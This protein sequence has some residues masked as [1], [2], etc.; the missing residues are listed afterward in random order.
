MTK[1]PEKQELK[2]SSIDHVTSVVKGAIGVVPFAGPL[3][4]E[5]AGTLIPNQRI[6]RL[7]KFSE[8]HSHRL[9]DVEENK[10][11]TY[12]TDEN[13]TDAIE[14]SLRLAARSTSE[15]GR[16]SCRSGVDRSL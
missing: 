11:R 3:L 14:E 13:F 8:E 10:V 2:N 4:A 12:L 1:R 5:I 6:D 9:K 15:I 7:V 16:A